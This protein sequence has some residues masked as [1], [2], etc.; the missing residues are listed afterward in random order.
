LAETLNTLGR[1]VGKKAAIKSGRAIL[2]EYINGGIEI[3]ESRPHIIDSA[4]N[5]LSKAVGAP[6]FT[7]CLVMSL[8]DEYKTEYIFGFDST[9]KKNG[10]KIP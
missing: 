3:T 1:H 2:E 10:Y 5:L 9:L 8:A 7:D 4:L 6:S